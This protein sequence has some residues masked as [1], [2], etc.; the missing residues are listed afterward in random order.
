MF[1]TKSLCVALSCSLFSV[2]AV[3]E[4]ITI[5]HQFVSGTPAKASEVNENFSIIAEALNRNHIY[6]TGTTA[7][8]TSA[9][10]EIAIFISPIETLF[11]GGVS[12]L[13]AVSDEGYLAV[14]GRSQ[15]ITPGGGNR[16][17]LQI[18]YNYQ[19][20]VFAYE[21]N[22]C[23][24]QA[25]FVN[26]YFPAIHGTGINYMPHT[27]RLFYWS[28]NGPAGNQVY[29][30]DGV[31]QSVTLNSKST[32]PSFCTSIENTPVPANVAYAIKPNNSA[33]TGFDPV[34]SP[35]DNGFFFS[36]PDIIFK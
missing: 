6:S 14:L 10:E 2:S 34:F 9:G 28:D 22:D 5:P 29:Y 8:L 30:I 15:P 4:E 12:T 26:E 25:F 27:K 33:V 35:S 13:Y 20:S 11:N 36:D 17:R 3:A 7:Y 24:G 23:S 18:S 1:K 21:S 19:Q 32:G 31:K 16:I